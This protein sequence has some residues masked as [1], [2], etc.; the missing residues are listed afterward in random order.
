MIVR[1]FTYTVRC[2]RCGS[3]E[4]MI[5]DNQY[6]FNLKIPEDWKRRKIALVYGEEEK[7]YCEYCTPYEDDDE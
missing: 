5:S 7:H 4:R 2:D 6:M 1:T 3:G